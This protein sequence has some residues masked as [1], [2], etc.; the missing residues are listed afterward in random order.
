MLRKNYIT[1]FVLTVGFV[2]ALFIGQALAFQRS[3]PSENKVMYQYDTQIKPE[4]NSW[5]RGGRPQEVA[6]NQNA[7]TM[8]ITKKGKWFRGG[9]YYDAA[10]KD[11]ALVNK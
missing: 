7:D 11:R 5:S 2:N 1:R 9:V 6:S 4:K 8:K 10:A 3:D